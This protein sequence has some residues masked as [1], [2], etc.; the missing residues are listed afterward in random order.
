M[1]IYQQLNSQES[2]KTVMELINLEIKDNDE[3]LQKY[4]SIV[5]PAHYGKRAYIWYI[6]NTIGE[7]L[8]M[9]II[10]LDLITRLQ[11]DLTVIIMWEKWEDIIQAT[12]VREN[13]PD[14]WEG[15]EYLHDEMIKFR[16]SRG[17]PEIIGPRPS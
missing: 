14:L 17:Y 9:G 6:Y 8:R 11:L 13:I 2:H 3:Y 15:F 5:N 16:S 7:L 1:Q 4:D 10:E 12:R